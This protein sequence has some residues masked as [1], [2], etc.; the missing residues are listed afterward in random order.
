MPW[1]GL[2]C[3]HAQGQE[4]ER[5]GGTYGEKQKLTTASCCAADTSRDEILIRSHMLLFCLQ[6]ATLFLGTTE[7]QERKK[8]RVIMSRTSIWV[9]F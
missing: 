8:A 5:E 3:F 1:V 4:G 9:D 6:M 2:S 7:Q